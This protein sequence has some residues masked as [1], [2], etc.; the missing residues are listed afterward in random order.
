VVWE[1]FR[2]Y[3]FSSKS[4][5]VVKKIS[6]LSW[7]GMSFSF[8]SLIL[9][10]S[11]MTALNHNIETKTLTV[12]PHL[13]VALPEVSDARV[14]EIHPVASRLRDLGAKV[15]GFEHQDVILR[16]MDGHFRGAQVRGLSQD[17]L[18]ELLKTTSFSLKKETLGDNEVLMGSDL[19][20][21]LGV[22]E[23]DTVMVVPPEGL[24]L[25]LSQIPQFEKV[26]V[27]EIISTQ[28]GQVDSSVIFFVQGRALKTF[29]K[30]ASRKL[31][32]EVWTLNPHRLEKYVESLRVFPQVQVETWKQRNSALFLALRIEKTVITFFLS[33]AS[34]LALFSLISVIVL[35]ISQK[36]REIGLLQALGMSRSQVQKLF[37]K[38]S[39]LLSALGLGTGVFLGSSLSLYIEKNPV[40]G[41]LPADVYYDAVIPAE[42]EFSLVV[43]VLLVG[44]CLCA[45]GGWYSSKVILE[46]DPSRDLRSKAE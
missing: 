23:G 40:K 29:Q 28:I 9:V 36:R 24:L 42:W 25:P 27:K 22:F 8:A 2:K 35:L 32:L 7:I 44:G 3:L 45:V 43:T 5:A 12:E 4:G 34:L 6:W 30:A 10:L 31:G 19:A 20:A 26:I 16:T 37:W 14:L 38:I 46:S 33:V 1:F 17:S 21:S 39:L 11:V 13:V 15:S 41:L 18:G